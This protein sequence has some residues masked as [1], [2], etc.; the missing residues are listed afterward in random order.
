LGR[1]GPAQAAFTNP[2]IKELGTLQNAEVFVHPDEA[3]LDKLSQE[4]L[5]L[6][7]DKALQ[8]KIDII[9]T[10]AGDPVNGKPHKIILRFLVSPIEILRD[11]NNKV[12]GLRLEKNT[13]T[14]TEAGTLQPMGTGFIEEVHAGLVFH[15]IGYRGIPLPDIPFNKDWGVIPNKKGRVTNQENDEIIHGL[16]TAGWIKRGPTGVIGTNKLDASKTVKCML[17][18]VDK[19]IY[20]T[21]SQTLA[22]AAEQM[23]R[24]RQPDYV[25]F[26]D[27][28]HLDQIEL[29][30]GMA[31]DRPRV[32]FTV[33]DEMLSEVDE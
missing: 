5:D 16:Y 22:K 15:S 33:I 10:Y 9:Q 32:K 23:V 2:E 3:C 30:R 21:P 13:L 17:E 31:K 8:R 4:D 11:V 28:L 25:I 20:L 12:K 7:G 29:S 6:R 19:G 27:W 24:N 26:K 18:D 14:R 1:R